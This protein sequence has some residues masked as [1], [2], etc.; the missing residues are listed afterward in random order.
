MLYL[1]PATA[2]PTTHRAVLALLVLMVSFSITPASAQNIDL[3]A[4]PPREDVQLTI[5][6]AVDLTLVRERRTLSFSPGV[7]KLEFSWA[8]TLIDPSSVNLKFI[9]HGEQ[10]T[11]IDTVYPHDRPQELNWHIDSER[12][13]DAIVEISYFTSGISWSADYVIIASEDESTAAVESY[14]TVTNQSGENYD[15]AQI[16]LVVGKIHMVEAIAQLAQTFLN[17]SR[18]SA[19][20]LPI[21]TRMAVSESLDDQVRFRYE[22]GLQRS[23]SGRNGF[24]GGGGLFGDASAPEV[25]KEGL[26]EYFIFTVTGRHD[27]PNGWSK[28]MLSLTTDAAP[29][30][31]QY[32]YRPREY[33][34]Q[35]VKVYAITNDDASGLGQS[36]LP[37]GTVRTY[38]RRGSEV[39]AAGQQAQPAQDALS[40]LA[41]EARPYIA[42]TDDLELNLGADPN[43]VFELAPV[44]VVRD[45]IWMRQRDRRIRRILVPGDEL[46]EVAPGVAIDDDATVIGWQDTT[47]YVQHIRNQ[48]QRAIE[49]EVRRLVPG[50]ATWTSATETFSHDAQTAQYT[51]TVAPGENAAVH[52][53]IARR[54]GHNQKQE[55]LLIDR[56]AP[57]APIGM[58]QPMAS[59]LTSV[60]TGI[61]AMLVPMI[62][63]GMWRRV[64]RCV[65]ARGGA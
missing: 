29:L 13:G 40:F 4:A 60:R 54:F 50:D 21:L 55:R 36:P 9:E 43:V 35:L 6:N 28:R 37:D 8:N 18:Q 7:N 53:R 57:E 42:V 10:L 11:L 12:N 51:V 41:Q 61:V 19:V 32:R 65:A 46:I 44:S 59:P 33:G 47:R 17:A 1:L 64:G 20:R 3:A 2:R 58:V 25:I 5:Y 56:P 15:G 27:T 63:I 16:R 39:G 49:V 26:S 52:Y 23:Q 48:T 34:D 14:V 62:G 45:A 22:E 30:K 31:V 24:G 38:R